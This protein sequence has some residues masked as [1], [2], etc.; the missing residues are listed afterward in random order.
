MLRDDDL[1]SLQE[2]R[3]LAEKAYQASRQFLSFTQE[4]V[5]AIIDAMAQ[6]ATAAAQDLAREA[7]AETGY[8][9]EADKVVKNLFASQDVYQA[10]RGMKTV[11]V[12]REDAAAKVIEIAVP[13]GVV[14]AVLPTTNPTSTA[15][16]KVL[17]ALKGR[18]AIVLSPHPNAIQC[19]C[20]TA[21]ILYRAAREAGAPEHVINCMKHPSMAGTNELMKH[22]RTGVILSTGGASVVRAAYSSGKPAFGVGPGNVPALLERSCNVK[23]AVADVVRGKT[24]DNGTLCS[25]EQAL[26]AEESLRQEVLAELKSQGAYFLNEAESAAVARTLVTPNFTV[27][28]KYAGKSATFIAQGAG[29]TVPPETRLLIAPMTGVGREHPLSAEKLSPVLCLYFVKDFAAGMDVAESLLRFGG[30]G[31]T[32]SIHSQDDARIREYGLRMPAFRVVANSPST[33]GAVGY[34]TSFFP[35]MTLGCGAVGGNVTSDNISPLHLINIRRIGYEKN[36]K[37]AAQPQPVTTAMLT[38]DK[39]T[40]ARIVEQFLREKGPAPEKTAPTPAPAAAAPA[41]PPPPAP[42]V[43]DFVSESDVRTARTR[44]EKILIGP[45]TIVTPAARDLAS[46]ADVLV[47]V[48]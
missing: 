17:I 47:M 10:I 29:L 4:K 45:R 46:D 30:M 42:K 33:L 11:G 7:V 23:K 13:V 40:I 12:V 16:Y 39:P 41:P 32:C 1:L 38:P 22:R 21:D 26:I 3:D 15:I 28:S 14:A 43:V 36:S 19:I 37:P 24:F 48:K 2:A 18:N 44:S 25:S 6:A 9:V 8:G 20:H 5:D 34:T 27:N 35:A 31:H